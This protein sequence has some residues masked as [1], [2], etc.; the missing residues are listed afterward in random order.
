MK[1]YYDENNIQ[2]YLGDCREILPTLECIQV[3]LTDPPYGMNNNT[4]TTRFSGGHNPAHRGDGKASPRPR[5]VG[6]DVP[7]NPTHLIS[8]PKVIIW[9][10]NHFAR[11]LPVGTTLIWVKR[12]DDAFGSFLSDAEV[13]WMKGGCGVYCYRDLSLLSETRYRRHP[14]EKPLSLMKWCIK[15][16][17]DSWTV[18]LICDPYMGS[19]TTLRAAK[20][21]GLRAIG[22]EIDE[23][24][25]E[26]AA[27]RMSQGV[28]DFGGG[29]M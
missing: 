24:Y 12:F 5:V 23:H 27:R 11:H 22:I 29:R 19:G 4:D 13:A 10:F 14:T 17:G 28:F 2:I 15:R 16:L 6:D 20:D 25:C 1:P 9:G 18:G 26:V 8:Y 21:M 3:I 7:F